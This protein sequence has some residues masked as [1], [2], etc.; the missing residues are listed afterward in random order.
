MFLGYQCMIHNLNY[1]SETNR[2]NKAFYF[3]LGHSLY[4]S[5]IIVGDKNVEEENITE[6]FEE[7]EEEIDEN[8]ESS[9]E[10][11][12]NCWKSWMSINPSIDIKLVDMM[13]YYPLSSTLSD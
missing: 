6:N 5:K 9:E 12:V 1:S 7:N 10:K 3:D 8:A 4:I 2:S 13:S 11:I